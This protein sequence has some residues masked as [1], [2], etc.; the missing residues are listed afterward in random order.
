MKVIIPVAGSLVSL[1]QFKHPRG[2]GRGVGESR[3]ESR[4][5][6]ERGLDLM[7]HSEQKNK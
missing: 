7:T 2:V 5:G 6:R 1:L 3:K 4:K